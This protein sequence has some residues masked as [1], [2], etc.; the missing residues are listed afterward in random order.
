[1]SQGFPEN[2]TQINELPPSPTMWEFEKYGNYP[3]SMHTGVPNI[4]IPF[5]SAQSGPISV[6]ISLSYHASG[7]QVNQRASW[8]GLGWTLRAGGAIT[9][10]V[11]GSA[12]ESNEGYINRVYD[13]N[14]NPA[15]SAG[16]TEL[17]L[18]GVVD[19]EPDI[20]S[21]DFM[22]YSGKF[23]FNHSSNR[24]DATIAL[25]PH[26]DLAITPLFTGNEIVGFSIVT[27]EGIT[28]EFGYPEKSGHTINGPNNQYYVSSTNVWHLKKLTGPN[29]NDEIT[30]EYELVS[31]NGQVNDWRYS[32]R[33]SRYFNDPCNPAN[34][35]I[36]SSQPHTQPFSTTFFDVK[37]IS[38]VNF[39]NGYILFQSSRGNRE[40][41]PADDELRLDEVKLY[42]TID[43]IDHPI[44]SFQ[45]GFG[46]FGVPDSGVNNVKL[47]LNTVTEIASNGVGSNPYRFSYSHNHVPPRF[48]NSQ[49]YW[50]YYN[51][52]SNSSLAPRVQ[53]TE[54][55][56]T[57]NLGGADRDPNP[58][59]A[60]H[61]TL[62]KI[63]FPTKG[64][65]LFEYEGNTCRTIESGQNTVVE[66]IAGG[67]RIKKISSMNGDDTIQWVKSYE[68]VQRDNPL[69]SSGVYNG[70]RFIAS[71]DF[72]Y[73]RA[74]H[75]AGQ[76]DLVQE[77]NCVPSTNI[78]TYSIGVA[79]SPTMSKNQA[80]VFYTS[81]KE[82]NGTPENHQ[83]YTWYH[84]ADTKD[85]TY[86]GSG[87]VAFLVDRSWDR[88][89]LLLQETFENGNPDPISKT[90]N[91]YE[92]INAQN[93]VEGFKAGARWDVSRE[94]Y[95]PSDQNPYSYYSI[96]YFLTHYTEPIVWKRLKKSTIINDGITTV[97]DFFYDNGLLHTNLVKTNTTIGDLGILE[98][99]TYYPDDISDI[100]SLNEGGVLTP[101][102]RDQLLLLN[103]ANQH[104]TATPIQS[105][106]KKNG[107]V[108]SIQR[109][110]YK[111]V[112]N[113]IVSSS[114]QTNKSSQL[115]ENRVIY[116]EYDDRGNLL[117]VSQADGL[118]V[119]YLWGYNQE[120][121]IAKIENLKSEDITP[122]LQ[123]LIDTA[124]VQSDK[125]DDR[126]LNYLGKEGTLR[127][128]LDNIRKHSVLK[129]A[130]V[131]T[132]TYDPLIGVTSVT[133]PKGYT[134]YYIYDSF[135]RLKEVR[136]ANGDILTDYEYHFKGETN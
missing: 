31:S 1:M 103:K 40:D 106:T 123:S 107:K 125:D 21:Y 24:L 3:V 90:I 94:G 49:D 43:G 52:K 81:V 15:D 51:G 122:E 108:L 79:S 97:K 132:Y 136:D 135:N 14:Y 133:D 70:N 116:H 86:Q 104:R 34:Y 6:P 42:S 62:N 126:T 37:K 118:H 105:V 20:F 100:N 11:R 72:F 13:G 98:T 77:G 127:L 120:Y 63:V 46:Y 99:K 47:K 33:H 73:R 60:E 55:G 38:K 5:F 58:L 56:F 111:T 82:Y 112:Y 130:M 10:T 89:Q 9:R 131:T 71:N 83:G 110:L 92:E 30:F 66:K 53:T 32:D 101:D 121:P 102:E 117:E 4:S 75:F 65:T 119:L 91:E 113:N 19:T 22:G 61:G 27:P 2:P 23:V 78:V 67:L 134:T 96:R 29:N 80:T 18:L 129:G 16:V 84:Y 36:P 50:G 69:L 88:G 48:S 68:Y 74:Y 64:Y 35:D 93:P 76:P 39:K 59:F 124:R 85:E 45:L 25:I 41:D 109:N 115:L 114:I 28:A 57:F 95:Y 44:K 8:T 17:M 54:A 87:P 26:A 12:D 128:T 7:V